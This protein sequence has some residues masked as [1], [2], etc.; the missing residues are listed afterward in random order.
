MARLAEELQGRTR[1]ED[2]QEDLE[3]T[4]YVRRVYAEVIKLAVRDLIQEI[5]QGFDIETVD[6]YMVREEGQL[7]RDK[8]PKEINNKRNPRNSGRKR[9]PLLSP[10]AFIFGEE[11]TFVLCCQELGL[12]PDRMREQIQLKISAVKKAVSEKAV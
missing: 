1:Y 12:D 2:I 6:R 8:P 3:E 4:R 5:E 10:H 7:P 9:I 11:G